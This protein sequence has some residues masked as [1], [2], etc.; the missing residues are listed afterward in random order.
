MFGREAPPE[1]LK[2]L[3][4]ICPRADLIYWGEGVWMLGRWNPHVRWNPDAA[5]RLDRIYE[6][7]ISDTRD[8]NIALERMR[9]RGFARTTEFR[10]EG[11]ENWGLIREDFRRRIFNLHNRA[12]AALEE[13]GLTPEREAGKMLTEDALA[14]GYD[15]YRHLR[16]RTS[17][18]KT[19]D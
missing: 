14:E 5:K 7:P 13:G 11:D 19:W 6:W 8:R 9:L 16:G 3:R 17:V 10:F 12:I 15:V 18:T 1:L 2:Q 4:E